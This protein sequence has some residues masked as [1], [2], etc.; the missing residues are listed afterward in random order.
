[1]A[2]PRHDGA[3]ARRVLDEAG[4]F[5]AMTW[6]MAIMLFLTILSAALGLGTGH[7]TR[8][9]DRQLSGRLTVQIVVGD[10]VRRDALAARALATLRRVPGVVHAVP[11][12]RAE[13]ERLLAPWLG[14]D[15]AD[16]ALPVPAMI[17]VDL[18]GDGDAARVAAAMAAV[19]PAIR[20]DRHEAW[21]SPVSGFMTT[22]T[23]LAAALV[24]LMAVATG[25]VV[26]LAARAG[27]ETHRETISVMHMLGSTDVQVARLFQRRIAL[28]AAIG[29]AIG[30]VAAF[31][32]VLFLG[33]RL[34]ALGSELLGGV[35]LG[36]GDW[37]LLALL[38]PFFVLLAMLAART[39]VLGTLRRVL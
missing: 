7:A 8:S 23:F 9:L 11:V 22:M 26:L 24:V 2:R 5:G 16:P 21:M 27:L 3:R 38:P 20:V 18:A 29:G 12:P 35:T 28:D 37:I 1:M 36:A 14:G 10:P 4:G 34:Q 19:D 6:V 25:A 13:L 32:V 31:A 33:L 30:A 39:A 15:A 17:D